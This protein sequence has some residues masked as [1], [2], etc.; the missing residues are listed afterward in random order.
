MNDLLQV[1]GNL[2][3]QIP[4]GMVALKEIIT[5]EFGSGGMFAL[6][7]ILVTTTVLVVQSLVKIF[8]KL[9]KYVLIP[10]VIL[11]FLA[12]RFLEIPI[13]DALTASVCICVIILLFKN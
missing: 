10:S 13:T 4:D 3:N 6:A 9:L 7:I 5:G 11:A 1:V 12:N 2:L 8:F